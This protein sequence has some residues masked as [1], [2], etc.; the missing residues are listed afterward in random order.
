MNNQ[1]KLMFSKKIHLWTPFLTKCSECDIWQFHEYDNS[2]WFNEESHAILNRKLIAEIWTLS[3]WPK[4]D[5]AWCLAARLA[6]L[7]MA[8]NSYLNSR[9]SLGVTY[10]LLDSHFMVFMN[11]EVDLSWMVYTPIV[12]P[13]LLAMYMGIAPQSL[14]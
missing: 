11:Y 12:T 4:E 2:L 1:R 9:R 10:T 7:N 14:V 5:G 3:T 6:R 13:H 8:L